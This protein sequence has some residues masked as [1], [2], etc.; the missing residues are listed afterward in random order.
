MSRV[1]LFNDKDLCLRGGCENHW[2]GNYNREALLVTDFKGFSGF[3]LNLL[4]D[5]NILDLVSLID[6]KIKGV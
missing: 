1:N 6:I 3:S 5:K 2:R 4:Q